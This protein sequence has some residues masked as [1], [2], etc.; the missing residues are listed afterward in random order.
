MED[1]Q[2]LAGQTVTF[3]IASGPNSVQNFTAQTDANG[4]ASFTYTSTSIGVDTIMASL[5]GYR[6]PDGTS[7]AVTKEWTGEQPSRVRFNL[8][9]VEAA[10]PV[11]L[12]HT[13]TATIKAGGDPV[14]GVKVTFTISS[15]PNAPQ[16]FTATTDANG[17][18]SFT[19]T[20]ASV[21]VD[22]IVA[23]AQVAGAVITSNKARKEWVG[24][25]TPPSKEVFIYSVKF[26]CGFIP[27][28]GDV[29][30]RD[31]PPVKPGNYATAINIQNVFGETAKLTYWASVALPVNAAMPPGPVSAG[32]SV[33]L[34][35]R[36]AVEIDCPQTLG[37]FAGTAVFAADFL[38]GFVVIESNVD[39]QVVAVYT[40]EKMEISASGT[41]IKIVLNTGFNQ[42][43]GTGLAYGGPDDDWEVIADTTLSV[44][45][46]AIVVSNQVVSDYWGGAA[47]T[48]S[49]WISTG[50]QAKPAGKETTYAYRFTL[51]AC[52]QNP[53]L[54]LDIKVDDIAEVFLNGNFIGLAPQWPATAT[55]PAT[56]TTSSFLRSGTN[57][58]TVALR[59]TGGVVMG[60]DATGTVRAI[61]PDRCIGVGMGIDVEYIQPKMVRGAAGPPLEGKPDLTIE[62]AQKGEFPIGG[63]GIYVITVKNIGDGTASSPIIVLETLPF[64]FTFI[65][66]SANP[67]WSCTV[68][69]PVVNP[70]TDQE[71]LECTYPGTLSP[72][73]SLT[74]AIE[75]NVNPIATRPPGPNCAE[76]RHPEDI[77]LS[78][79]KICI[80]TVLTL[81]TGEKPDLAIE[82]FLNSEFHY[83]QPASY[84]FLISNVG[85]GSADSPI[86]VVDD[87]PDGFTF[88]SYSDPYSTYW[89]CSASGQQVTCTYTGPDIAPGGFLPTL[90]IN[91]V[92]APID[93][94]PGGS[95][96]VANCAGVKHPADAN[97]DN[98]L[99]CVTT[100]ITR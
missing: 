28:F 94:F 74:L 97:P 86:T 35:Q 58:L 5:F 63:T 52:V 12:T 77:D 67:P 53:V 78:N 64:G 85:Q 29:P 6:H 70:S 30:A 46:D 73:G 60:F 40:S 49:R 14:E 33:E 79:N 22:T 17:E 91:V 47:L 72:G 71:V 42:S 55:T 80:D 96:A 11:G 23:E 36:Q 24:E 50:A 65:P 99:S 84:T 62:K 98:N 45:F 90:I 48:N 38:K 20:G 61:D 2:P 81:S 76:V 10:N 68:I 26:V 9:P 43:A 75:V 34:M 82:K 27:G 1:G 93:L 83:G 51:P 25:Q 89:S 69:K 56:V 92:I 39:L 59:D 8:S 18:A 41:P 13:V 44:P 15:G 87:L 31:E 19:Y 3:T 21:G 57:V 66:G 7:N 4:S 95:D 88:V 16:T 54:Q 100:V 32:A 37:L